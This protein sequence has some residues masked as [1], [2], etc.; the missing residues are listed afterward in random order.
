M[1]NE[2]YIKLN[3]VI[4]L[5]I[6]TSLLFLKVA[7]IVIDYLLE[8]FQFLRYYI[9]GF[10]KGLASNHVLHGDSKNNEIQF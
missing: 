4:V 7:P 2:L 6:L 5:N 8:Q 10:Q 3:N 1:P 9:F